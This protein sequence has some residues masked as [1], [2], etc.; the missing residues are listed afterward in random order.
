MSSTDT[1]EIRGLHVNI[2]EKE[3]LKGVDL[4]V[5]KGEVHALMGPNGSGKSTL[6]NAILG[7]PKYTVT[8]GKVI[9]KGE[10]ILEMDTDERA[11]KGLFLAFQ[12]PCEVPGVRQSNFLRLACNARLGREM[13]VTDFY[14]K[15][16]EKMKVLD[17]DEKF[18]KRYLNEGFSGGEKKRNEILQM[19][20]LEPEFAIMDETDSGLDIDALKVV[21]RGVNELRGPGL[22]I[23]IIT[24]YERI[25]RYINP[26]FVHI[27]V[28][29]R[30]VKSGGPDLAAH[31]EEHGYDWIVKDGEPATAPAKG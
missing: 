11:R 30:I 15:L 20:M 10:D 14:S 24:H 9:M 31:L 26:D 18:M 29:G 19:M 5:R 6:A 13:D 17:I 22:G 25:L 23:L 1:F 2:E 3:I 27:M 7:H 16:E 4:V 8:G 21:S 28:D 12:Y